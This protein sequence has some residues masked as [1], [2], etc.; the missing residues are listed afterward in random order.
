[1]QNNLVP[2]RP[3]ESAWAESTRL[4]Y[5]AA[6]QRFRRWCIKHGEESLPASEETV[7]RYF[8]QELGTAHPSMLAIAKAAI[9][10]THR[11]L[12][13]PDPTEAP[14]VGLMLRGLK[15]VNRKDPADKRQAE[16]ISTE[17]LAA[18]IDDSDCR[19]RVAYLMAFAAGLR[20]SEVV[21]VERKHLRFVD[22]GVE[23]LIP[24]SK[25]DQEG[26]GFV[27]AI[28]EIG[29]P[30][31]PVQ[32]LRKF[33]PSAPGEGPIFQ[34]SA[35]GFYRQLKRK[36]AKLGLG[37]RITP[38]SFR[39]GFATAALSAGRDISEVA[40]AG[41]WVKLDTVSV[42]DRRSR[43][44]DPISSVVL[45]EPGARGEAPKLHEPSPSGEG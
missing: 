36:A 31:C 6:W 42:Y 22:G 32:A 15:R 41:R 34:V 26:V 7:L 45:P 23:L 14:R 29:G 19:Y 44:Q 16:P 18:L 8:A 1:M 20:V 12:N 27:A 39:A 28:A 21:A 24:K 33:L 9:R 38:H 5:G 37:E 2:L 17:K 40:K 25:T 11:V 35:N 10:Q 30:F 4:V 43:W 13:L 3:I